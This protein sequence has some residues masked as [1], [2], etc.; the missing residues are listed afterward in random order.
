MM[1]RQ[2]TRTHCNGNVKTSQK[3]VLRRAPEFP[4]IRKYLT[5]EIEDERSSTSDL[6]EEGV[7]QQSP[8]LSWKTALMGMLGFSSVSYDVFGAQSLH[9]L[10]PVDDWGHAMAQSFDPSVREW[11]WRILVSDTS[12]AAGTAGWLAMTVLLITQQG[13]RTWDPKP[14]FVLLLSWAFNC[15]VAGTAVKDPWVIAFLKESFHRL[16]PS[17]VLSSFSYPSGH[18]SAATFLVASLLF[19][20]IPL[21]LRQ[22]PDLAQ[23]F[24]FLEA[25]QGSWALL[26]TAWVM[27]A[28]GRVFG[29]AHW[30]SDTIA[31]GFLTL[32][33]AS[34]LSMCSEFVLGLS[35][36]SVPENE[37][38][39]R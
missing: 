31:G 36:I 32:G 34:L 38:V 35:K 13:T 33:A 16:R 14:I 28:V 5:R 24:S 39:I 29:D 8:K 11:L 25:L 20:L 26:G 9:L 19:I 37:K 4:K 3:P 6:V 27:T 22:R 30:V 2:L 21:A 15:S 7:L 18:T 17:P 10:Q 1:K 23:R 12:I